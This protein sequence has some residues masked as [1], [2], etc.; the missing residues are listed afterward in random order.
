M[1]IRLFILIPFFVLG[2]ILNVFPQNGDVKIKDQK[3]IFELSN[4]YLIHSISN[5][6]QKG[7]S[8]MYGYPGFFS[9]YGQTTFYYTTP[10]GSSFSLSLGMGTEYIMVGMNLKVIAYKASKIYLNVN[11]GPTAGRWR[12]NIY[13]LGSV[14]A[15]YLLENIMDD[16]SCE[17]SFDMYFNHGYRGLMLFTTDTPYLYGTMINIHF[18]K[19]LDKKLFLIYGAGFS[20]IEYCYVINQ[21]LDYRYEGFYTSKHGIENAVRE[22]KTPFWDSEYI[23]PFGVSLIYYFQKKEIKI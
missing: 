23:I 7:F 2:E 18:S 4:P 8:L 21:H 5:A 13:Y 16:V 22:G 19:K 6:G 12:E 1:N 20:Y 3:G 9:R 14:G 11:F 15:S 17:I 10:S